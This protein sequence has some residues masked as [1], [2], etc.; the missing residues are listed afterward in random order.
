MA[1]ATVISGADLGRRLADLV[2]IGLSSQ[3]TTRL[4]WTAELEQAERWFE[5][6]ADTGGLGF[7]RDPAGNLWAF[8]EVAGPWW[9]TGSHLDSVPAGGRYDGAL[10]VA[11]GFEIAARTSAP[12]AVISFA[13]EEGGRFGTPTFGSR[14]LAGRLDPGP[15]LDRPDRDGV[16]LEQALRRAGLDPDRLTEASERI[17]QLA[18]FVELHIDQTPDVAQA[19]EPAGIVGSLAARVRLLATVS[20]RADHAGTTRGADRRDAMLAAARLIVRASELSGPQDVNVSVPRLQAHP[21]ASTTL[22]AEVET[23]ID[24]RCADQDQLGR[25]GAEFAGVAREVA[26]AGGVE[27]AVGTLS[28]SPPVE[29][30]ADLR[31]RLRSLGGGI[32]EVVCWAGHDAGILAPRLPAAM[33]LVRNPTGVSHAPGEEVDLD[34]AA[35]GAE[36]IARLLDE[37]AMDG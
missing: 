26:E 5:A 4:A 34:D 15:I 14:A 35:A 11:A 29:F 30:D 25:W 3:G 37:M 21:N 23:W 13:D 22:P 8:P 31:R 33:V 2:P 17:A 32:P 12:V 24:A 36:L 10:G 7:D 19:G 9:A 18:G 27:I 20:G 28:E 16:T 6:Q 1:S